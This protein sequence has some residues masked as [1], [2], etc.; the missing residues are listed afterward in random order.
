M[1]RYLITGANGGMGR[2]ICRAL[3]AAG[4]EVWGIDKTAPE[5]EAPA[6]V[7]TADLTDAA[8]LECVFYN[9]RAE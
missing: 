2:A 1:A 7:I 9:L 3:T 4:D 5:A 6:R 8:S